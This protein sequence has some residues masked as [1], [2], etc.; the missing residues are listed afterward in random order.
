MLGSLV[1]SLIFNSAFKSSTAKLGF[2]FVTM[3]VPGVSSA[4]KA[5]ISFVYYIL[6]GDVTNVELERIYKLNEKSR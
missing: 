6:S 5:Y 3:V 2:L 1:A 4:L